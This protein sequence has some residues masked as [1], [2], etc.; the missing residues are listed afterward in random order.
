M[1]IIAIGD[2]HGNLRA[3]DDLLRDCGHPSIMTEM[4]DTQLEIVDEG[5]MGI[6][7]AH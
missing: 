6:M 1:S 4:M 7:D 3:L 5:I 2:I